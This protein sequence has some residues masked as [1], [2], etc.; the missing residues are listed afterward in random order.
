MYVHGWLEPGPWIEEAVLLPKL[1]HALDVDVLH[2]Q[3]PFHGV[4]NPISARFHGEFFWSGDLVRTIEALRQSC[5]DA[6]TLVAWLRSLGYAEVGV[7]GI[8]LGGSIAMLL[9]CVAPLPDYIVPIVSHLQ[10]A[11]AVEEAPILWRMKA[12]LEGFGVGRAQR[13]DI[14]RRLG[15]ATMRP[16]LAPERQ[17]WIMARND[18]YI[19]AP[20]VERQWHAWGEPPIEW[21]AGGHMTF[22]LSLGRIVERT[23]SFHAA[24]MAR[25]RLNTAHTTRFRPI[26]LASYMRPSALVSRAVWVGS[27][28]EASDDTPKLAVTW[29][30]SPRTVRR[31]LSSARRNRSASCWPPRSEVLRATTTNSS[32]PKRATTSSVRTVA[33]NTWATWRSTVSPTM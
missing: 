19:A 18:V 24:L 9:A 17:L 26:D 10:L 6:R 7:T 20:L 13:E 5:I 31:P 15:I 2:V 21:I 25:G 8:S 27:G 29:S 30:E 33:A 1:D 12:D 14:F 11:E 22:P 28:V 23:R 16:L 3:L 32:P 4:R